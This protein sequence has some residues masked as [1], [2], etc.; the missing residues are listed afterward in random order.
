MRK[1][2]PICFIV[3]ALQMD[4]ALGNRHFSHNS[5]IH[6]N[7]NRHELAHI[8]LT[9][10]HKLCIN[11]YSIH[12]IW[13]NINPETL[14]GILCECAHCAYA[15]SFQMDCFTCSESMLVRVRCC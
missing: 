5:T 4:A 11:A 1:R 13:L 10:I 7:T 6:V 12:G 9:R 3:I 14:S 8:N 15:K 2:A